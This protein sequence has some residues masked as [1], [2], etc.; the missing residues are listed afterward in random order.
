MHRGIY[1][2]LDLAADDLVG[3]MQALTVHKHEAAAVRFFTDIAAT[4]GSIVNK[5]PEDFVLK[6][7]GFLDENNDLVPNE[8]IIL[9]GTAWAATQQPRE[10]K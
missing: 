2:V 8:A 5:H 6:R 10:E 3:Q 7:L 1:A 4:Q 9:S